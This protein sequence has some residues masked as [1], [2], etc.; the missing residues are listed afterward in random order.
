MWGI[1]L[2]H[3]L[4]GDQDLYELQWPRLITSLPAVVLKKKKGG[5]MQNGSSS[6]QQNGHAKKEL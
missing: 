3:C 4:D 2:R 5:G 1:Y 6:G